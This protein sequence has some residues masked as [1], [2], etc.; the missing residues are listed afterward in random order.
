[1]QWRRKLHSVQT[2]QQSYSKA[3]WLWNSWIVLQLNYEAVLGKAPLRLDSPTLGVSPPA[4]EETQSSAFGAKRELTYIDRSLHR[5][6]PLAWTPD[7][8]VLMQMRISNPC[9]MIGPK[10]TVLIGQNETALI[11]QWEPL[12][13]IAVQLRLGRESLNPIAWNRTLGTPL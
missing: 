8:S 11:G 7:W 5:Q 3:A 10:G 13:D 12:G 4:G 6:K 9:R 2:A 1:M